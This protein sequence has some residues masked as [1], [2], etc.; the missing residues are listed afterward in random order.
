MQADA[1]W[2]WRHSILELCFGPNSFS[3]GALGASSQCHTFAFWASGKKRQRVQ[4]TPCLPLSA[5]LSLLPALVFWFVLSP[6]GDVC[7]LLS[8][9]IFLRVCLQCGLLGDFR[10]MVK[11]GIK[12]RNQA[13]RLFSGAVFSTEVPRQ[14]D[15]LAGGH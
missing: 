5:Q 9:L 1:P 14:G 11:Q 4:A 6:R 12:E 13:G 15:V 7:Q 8:S 3:S 10:R 2:T